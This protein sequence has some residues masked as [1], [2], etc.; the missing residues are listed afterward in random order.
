MMSR[1]RREG[2]EGPV[3]IRDSPLPGICPHT[4]THE[5]ST[6][7]LAKVKRFTIPQE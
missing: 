4:L 1:G 2:K 5:R 3:S 7:G 6:N